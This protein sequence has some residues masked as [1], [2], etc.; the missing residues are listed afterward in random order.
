M[1]TIEL[2]LDQDFFDR[3]PDRLDMKTF[4]AAVGYITMW[5]IRGNSKYDRVVVAPDRS[6]GSFIASY[7]NTTNPGYGYT[8]LASMGGDDKSG[9]FYSFHS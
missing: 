4:D 2:R 6:E 8:I 9:Y 5:A 3:L 1:R 7:S